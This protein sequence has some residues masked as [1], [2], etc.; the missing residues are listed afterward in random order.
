MYLAVSLDSHLGPLRFWRR[1][2]APQQL[3]MTHCLPV[4]SLM[5]PIPALPHQRH[6]S[7]LHSTSCI[8]NPGP[9][10]LRR[11]ARHIIKINDER[12]SRSARSPFG[13][14]SE[15]RLLEVR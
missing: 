3:T 11:R 5:D 14:Q 2:H 9:I 6:P 12:S 4:T 8:F 7:I 15:S 10:A 1:E 13:I